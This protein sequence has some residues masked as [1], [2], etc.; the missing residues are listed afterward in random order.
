MP[1]DLVIRGASVVTS[2]GVE[3]GDL[4]IDGGKFVEG[5]GTEARRSVDGRGLL[6]LPGLIDSH[7]HFNDPGRADWEGVPTGSAALAAGGGTCFFDMPL[8]SS[9]PTLDADSFDQKLAVAQAGAVTDFGLWG[10][11]TP[12]NLDQLDELAARGVVGFKAF[13]CHSGIE[14]FAWAHE[15]S[16]RRGM[17]LAAALNL[18]VAV[19]AESPA[20]TARLTEEIRHRGGRAVADYLASRPVEAELEAI[21]LAIAL[22]EE[23]KCRLHIVH[24]SSPR[25]VELVRRAAEAKRC[26]VTCETCPHYLVL[27]AQDMARMGAP[28]KCAPPLRSAAESEALW[29]CLED[30]T[31]VFVASDHSPAPEAMKQSDDF[32]VVWGGIAGVQSTL[33][34]LLSRR[35]ALP[36]ELIA[37]LTAGNVAARYRIA[38]KGRIATGYDADLVLVEE[39]ARYE[40][41]REDLLDRHRMSP[42]VGRTFLGRVRQ[43]FVRGQVVFAEG[44]IVSAPI[45]RLVRP[46]V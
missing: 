3:V 16:L 5:G 29:Q 8:N 36:P 13:M 9:P 42:Y 38:S 40:L 1:I 35:P 10:G 17:Q 12:G 34:I 11:L 2:A 22:A 7:L 26:D 33:P 14:D 27:N 4:C 21:A 45:G 43:T 41:R 39:D 24:V 25:G 32:F 44:R 30:E 23:T 6:A 31:V 18:I 46:V 28:A 20:M 19:H 37:R 15:R